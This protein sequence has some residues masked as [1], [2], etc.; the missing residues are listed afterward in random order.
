M[1]ADPE[2]NAALRR[3]AGV[4][5]QQSMLQLDRAAD[6]V[7]HTAKLDNEAVACALDH[8]SAMDGDGRLDQVASQR[9]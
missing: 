2:L 3:Q 8:P 9:P 4:A 1:N 6:R 5:L 7:N